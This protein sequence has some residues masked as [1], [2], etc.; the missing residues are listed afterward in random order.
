MTVQ[1]HI[2]LQVNRVVDEAP[3]QLGVVDPAREYEINIQVA[4]G[5]AVTGHYRDRILQA[6][7][8]KKFTD[9]EVK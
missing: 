8:L 2:E 1:T 7:T 5:W 4:E 6:V 3:T 9:L